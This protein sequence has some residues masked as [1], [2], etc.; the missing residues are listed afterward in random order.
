MK[1]NNFKKNFILLA[2]LYFYFTTQIMSVNIGN[3]A[4]EVI[5]AFIEIPSNSNRKYEVDKQNNIIMVDRFLTVSMS[6][7]ANYGFI[8]ETQAK[9]GDPLDILVLTR[10]PV[11]PGCV[12]KSRPIGV[13]IME[14]EAGLDEKIISVPDDK[15]DPY[16]KN[17][18]ELKDIP[19][20]ELDK[21]HHFF[22]KYKDL[23]KG[24]WVKIKEY[25]DSKFAKELINLYKLNKK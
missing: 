4:P 22:E 23:E 14:D 13:L 7:P 19:Q 15:I 9:D 25:K 20:I 1:K 18:K 16:Y 8:P 2:F 11:V 24:K 17:I 21:I 12:I 5:N 10:F 6:Y 3:K